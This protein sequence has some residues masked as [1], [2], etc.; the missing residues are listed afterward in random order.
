MASTRSHTGDDGKTSFLGKGRISKAHPR[1]ETL[2]ALD[3]TS[4]ALGVARAQCHQEQIQTTIIEIQRDL[5]HIMAEVAASAETRFQFQFNGQER[6]TWLENQVETLSTSIATPNEFIVPGDTLASAAMSLA[7]TITRRAERNLVALT[8]MG[9][10][11]NPFHLQYL[12]RLST[13]CYL[14]EIHLA[15]TAGQS[16]PTKSRRGTGI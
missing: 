6:V 4:A 7:R 14:W 13:L 1:I 15:A 2:G 10:I 3:E 12:N 9:E 8:E 16:Q 5:Y 11:N